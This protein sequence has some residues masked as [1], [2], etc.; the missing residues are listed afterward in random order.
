MPVLAA[1]ASTHA[2][3]AAVC[4]PQ[5]GAPG[6]VCRPVGRREPCRSMSLNAGGSRASS[7]P[8]DAG[9]VCHQG[10]TVSWGHCAA[11]RATFSS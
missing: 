10:M 8:R 11:Q 2:T 7:T 3:D 5:R 9:S 1:S 6:N 4:T